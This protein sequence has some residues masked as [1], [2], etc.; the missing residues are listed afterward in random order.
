MAKSKYIKIN[1]ESLYKIGNK[2]IGFDTLIFNLSSAHN[3]VCDK[4]GQCPFGLRGNGKCYAL[5]NEKQYK[6]TL[7]Y[8][9]RQEEYWKKSTINKILLDIRTILVKHKEIKYIRFNESGDVSGYTDLKRLITVAETFPQITVYTYT[10]NLKL[11]IQYGQIELPKNLVI[12]GSGFCW[13][14]NYESVPK[15]QI[16][17]NAL[18]CEGNCRECNL[19][20][21]AH[22]QTVYEEI[23]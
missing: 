13:T 4:D 17:Y 3:C 21:I 16:P 8:R 6:G 15:G 11:Y 20:K 22:G 1:N 23:F 7:E 9:N 10:H 14:N 12:N 2:K 5:R 19:C 18:K